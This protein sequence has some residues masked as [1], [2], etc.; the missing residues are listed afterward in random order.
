MGNMPLIFSL[1]S[2]FLVALSF[3]DGKVTLLLAQK[4]EK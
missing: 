2:P 4:K 1:L 3:S